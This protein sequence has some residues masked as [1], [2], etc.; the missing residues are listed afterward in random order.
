MD[1]GFSGAVALMILGIV[2]WALLAL[3]PA[4][5]ARKKGH[6]FVL[7]MIIALFISFLLALLLVLLLPN[8]N[9][10]L[11]KADEAAVEAALREDELS[12]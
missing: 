11:T 12:T 1:I 9:Q 7:F 3:A 2:L 6:S 10:K 5:M 4:F 8:K